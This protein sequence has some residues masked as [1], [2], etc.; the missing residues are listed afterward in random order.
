MPDPYYDR[1]PLPY[2]AKLLESMTYAMGEESRHMAGRVVTRLVQNY[3]ANTA[4]FDVRSTYRFPLSGYVTVMNRIFQ[5]T[6]KSNTQLLG[7]TGDYTLYNLP[8]GAKVVLLT[9]YIV[10]PSKA[11][12][13]AGLVYPLGPV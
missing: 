11:P 9:R 8:K 6:S 4:T 2:P 10:P 1:Y 5:Y 7:L 12:G 3:T 13:V